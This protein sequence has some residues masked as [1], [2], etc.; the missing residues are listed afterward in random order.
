MSTGQHYKA[1]GTGQTIAIVHA[2]YDP[3][4]VND[5]NAFDQA[6]RTPGSAQLLVLPAPG[7]GVLLQRGRCQRG[8]GWADG[9][10]SG[11]GMGPCDRPGSQPSSWRGG[12]HVHRT[13]PAPWIGCAQQPG[14]SVVSMSW[15]G[16]ESSANTQYDSIF[17]TPAGHTGVTFVASA[18]ELR[19]DSNTHQ[20]NQVGVQ[21]PADDPDVL[22]VGGTSLFSYVNGTTPAESAWCRTLCWDPNGGGGRGRVQPGLCPSRPINTACRAPA[23][24]P[25][26]RF[27]GRRPV[28]APRSTTP[29]RRP[30]T[31]SAATSVVPAK[32]AAL[33]AIADQGRALANMLH[34]RRPQPDPAGPLRVLL[35][36]QIEVNRVQRLRGRSRLQPGDRPGCSPIARWTWWATWLSTSTRSITPRAPTRWCRPRLARWRPTTNP[37]SR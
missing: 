8:I 3:D 4:I 31:R 7:A 10:R 26:G 18:G 33:V 12:E 32:W 35:G 17:T 36:L 24:A 25:P 15:G 27:H 21:W 22:S 30:W 16:P 13:W 37:P 28:R 23:S 5:L 20:G 11:R 6:F 34:A 1:D 9:D 14:V 2:G 29:S 19:A